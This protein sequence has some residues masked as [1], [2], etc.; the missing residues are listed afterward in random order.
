LVSSVIFDLDNIIDNPMAASYPP[1]ESGGKGFVPPFLLIF[2]NDQSIEKFCFFNQAD[3]PTL[4]PLTSRASRSLLYPSRQET[5]MSDLRLRPRR[6]MLFSL[7]ALCAGVSAPALA[8]DAYPGKPIRLIVPY[9]PRR[10]HAIFRNKPRA[11]RY[12][13]VDPELTRP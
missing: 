13:E 12:G 11:V 5:Y 1:F 8:A 7:L 9:P 10:T 4:A 2:F 3:D 6:A